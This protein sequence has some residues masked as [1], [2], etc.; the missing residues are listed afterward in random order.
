MSDRDNEPFVRVYDRIVRR[1]WACPTPLTEDELRVMVE[2]EG[3]HYPGNRPIPPQPRVGETF[4]QFR[5]RLA[6][7][8][9]NDWF[10][11]HLARS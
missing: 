8:G 5:E 9:Q 7:E 3:L 1:F 2:A 10:P 6:R 4:A 11:A